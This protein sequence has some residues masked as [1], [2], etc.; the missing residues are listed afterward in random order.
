MIEKIL[1]AELLFLILMFFC[2]KKLFAQTNQR[3]KQ[4][5]EKLN[6][7]TEILLEIYKKS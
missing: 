4:V 3:L 5:V 6:N 1:F 2:F 7:I